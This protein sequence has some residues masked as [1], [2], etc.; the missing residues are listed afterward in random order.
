M[1]LYG[2]KTPHKGAWRNAEIGCRLWVSMP[3]ENA[4]HDASESVL[5]QCYLEAS[6]GHGELRQILPQVITPQFPIPGL[7]D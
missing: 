4:R 5:S 3:N 7:S 2:A 6:R 1:S